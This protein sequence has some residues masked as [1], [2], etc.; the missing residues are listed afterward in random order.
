[1]QVQEEPQK[2]EE[3]PRVEGRKRR[4]EDGAGKGGGREEDEGG[5]GAQQLDEAGVEEGRKD[6]GG[7]E[8]QEV[9]AGATR[10]GEAKVGEVKAGVGVSFEQQLPE[11]EAAEAGGPSVVRLRGTTVQQLHLPPRRQLQGLRSWET[12]AKGLAVPRETRREGRT[13][14]ERSELWRTRRAGR[15]RIPVRLGRRAAGVSLRGE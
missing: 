6:G 15:E 9:M 3:V 10:V 5:G 12:A 2:Q 14:F 11:V 7:V 13:H 8:L 1:M 4:E